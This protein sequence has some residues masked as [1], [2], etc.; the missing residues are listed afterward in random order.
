MIQIPALVQYLEPQPDLP[1]LLAMISSD[2]TALKF[3]AWPITGIL[4]K[5]IRSQG[6]TGLEY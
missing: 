3:A 4:S 6:P 5:K 1:F 2:P